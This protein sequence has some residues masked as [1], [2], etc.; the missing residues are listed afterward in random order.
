VCIG[1][2]IQQVQQ[3]F[4]KTFNWTEK[5]WVDEQGN[6]WFDHLWK[7]GETF[8]L[9]NIPCQVMETPGHTND[10]VS[11]LIGDAIFVG[12]SIFQVIYRSCLFNSRMLELHAVISLVGPLKSCIK[13]FKNCSNCLLKRE[14]L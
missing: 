10:S 1:E 14:C 5:D 3:T 8:Q 6:P 7:D 12:D 9:G 4:A 13:A 2:G 11:Y